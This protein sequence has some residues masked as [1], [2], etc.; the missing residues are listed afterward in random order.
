MEQ[1]TTILNSVLPVSLTVVAHATYFHKFSSRVQYD[2]ILH[3]NIFLLINMLENEISRVLLLTNRKRVNRA[4][5][6]NN[7][8][9]IFDAPN[10]K[11]CYKKQPDRKSVV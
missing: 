3:K 11:T 6:N 7:L 4:L 2:T 1:S 10:I 8:N 9:F 5:F